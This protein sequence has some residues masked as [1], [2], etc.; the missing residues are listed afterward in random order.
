MRPCLLRDHAQLLVAV[1]AHGNHQPPGIF[2]LLEQ[3]RRDLR[4]ARRHRNRIE[5]RRFR[6]PQRPVAAHHRHV[7]VAPVRRRFS[8]ANCASAGMISTVTT[9]AASAP[10]TAA[11]YPLPAPTSSTVSAPVNSSDF[12]HQRRHIR[13]RNGLPVADVNRFVLVRHQLAT[14]PA[15]T[16]RA[17][18]PAW[19]G[20]RP[21]RG[22]PAGAVAPPPF[23]AAPL[24]NP[25]SSPVRSQPYNSYPKRGQ[26]HLPKTGA[27]WRKR[28]SDS[29]RI[30]LAVTCGPGSDGGRRRCT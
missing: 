21:R 12:R 7:R 22:C 27:T 25:E 28:S 11:A 14:R 9:R 19:R 23:G 16:P 6:I 17:E 29:L 20:A 5:W 15:R 10:S 4:R 3:R 18:S 2:Q 8:R 30:P 13:L 24:P 26:T 1:I